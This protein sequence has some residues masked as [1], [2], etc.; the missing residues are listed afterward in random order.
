[1]NHTELYRAPRC[2]NQTK[3]PPTRWKNN[4]SQ[5]DSSTNGDSSSE[6]ENDQEVTFNTYHM[7]QVISSMFMPYLEGPKIDWTVYDGLYHR[8]L[9]MEIEM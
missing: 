8:C 1:M 3:L 7:Q 6:Q 5:D 9:K 2:Q 4:P